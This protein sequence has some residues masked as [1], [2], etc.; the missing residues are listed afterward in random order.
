MESMPIVLKI[1]SLRALSTPESA[2]G[3]NIPPPAQQGTM[4]V[5]EETQNHLKSVVSL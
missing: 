4:L 2:A 5:S 3:T 1:Q